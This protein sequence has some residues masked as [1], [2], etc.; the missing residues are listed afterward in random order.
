MSFSVP[1]DA[2]WF[3]QSLSETVVWCTGQPIDNDPVEDSAVRERRNLGSKA[4]ELVRRAFSVDKNEFWKSHDYARARR[5]FEKARLEEIAP[6]ENQLRSSFL[7]PR[8]FNVGQGSDERSSIVEDIV[9]KRAQRLHVEGQHPKTLLSRLP[10]GRLLC[11][12]PDENLS[13]GAARYASKGFFDVE[14]VPAWDTWVC[15]L[16]GHLVS[17][18]PPQ[19]VE[20]VACGIDVN[21]EG[22]I[23]WAPDGARSLP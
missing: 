15:F 19:L 6:L 22:C 9:Q 17:W 14:N 18:V 21:P 16:E 11:Y 1:V 13:D 4:A 12:L 20:L 5:L 8:P 2:P 7:K 23:F 10:T 3:R